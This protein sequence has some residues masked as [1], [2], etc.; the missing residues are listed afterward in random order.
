[1]TTKLVKWASNDGQIIK[2]GLSDGY[3]G[4]AITTAAH[5]DYDRHGF[6]GYP[7]N[8]GQYHG[9]ANPGRGVGVA[10]IILAL[11]SV[12]YAGVLRW[13]FDL[14]IEEELARQGPISLF[15]AFAGWL[16]VAVILPVVTG[17]VAL[18]AG[19]LGAVALA[20]LV[21]LL[22][23]TAWL[24]ISPYTLIDLTAKMMTEAK[25]PVISLLFLLIFWS[26][27]LMPILG[28]LIGL[29]RRS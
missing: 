2:S 7:G 11:L 6:E 27:I 17:I 3:G 5:L 22:Q 16:T 9:R 23:A 8:V 4:K 20:G 21:G 24:A 25:S 29:R 19:C 26:F 18:V 1:M 14:P 12:A 28:A 13:R 15:F 10:A